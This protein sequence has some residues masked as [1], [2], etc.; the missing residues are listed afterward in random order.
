MT[1]ILTKVP[2][3]TLDPEWKQGLFPEG[4]KGMETWDGA[5]QRDV[6]SG[7]MWWVR[8]CL[9]AIQVLTSH[10][11]QGKGEGVGQLVPTTL[12]YLAHTFYD[13]SCL[14]QIAVVNN[15]QQK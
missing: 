14:E 1:L 5:V 11:D 3:A 4:K 12:L 6:G 15:S 8:R 7:V 10:S 9:Q 2:G 13:T